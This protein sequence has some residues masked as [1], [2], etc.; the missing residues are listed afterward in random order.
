MEDSNFFPTHLTV[1]AGKANLQ[2]LMSEGFS[3]DMSR[4][5]LVIVDTR[6]FTFQSGTAQERLALVPLLDLFNHRGMV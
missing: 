1:V 2:Q 3:E 4:W 6:A 5:A